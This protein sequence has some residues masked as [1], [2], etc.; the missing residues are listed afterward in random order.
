MLTLVNVLDEM[1][2]NTCCNIG[3]TALILMYG[4][5]S[6]LKDPE[7]TQ[8]RRQIAKTPNSERKLFLPI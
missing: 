4:T 8:Q 7:E 6:R 3:E 1:L 5:F 2:G